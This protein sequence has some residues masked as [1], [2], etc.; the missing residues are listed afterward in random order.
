MQGAHEIALT[1][2]DVLSYMDR[3]PVC[4]DY[5]ID[6]VKTSKFPSGD[7]LTRA[8]PVYEYLEG[9]K[10][11]ISGCRQASDLPVAALR[12]IEFIENAVGCPIKYVSVG[13]E[14]EDYF[15]INNS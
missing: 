1:K 14:R 13:A 6:G 12:Y 2:L 3:I 10:A 4:V 5:S 9:F 7:A 15:T 8:K 11:D